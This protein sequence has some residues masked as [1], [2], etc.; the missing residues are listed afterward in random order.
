MS[1]HPSVPS[2]HDRITG[3]HPARHTALL[4]LRGYTDG[5]ARTVA[6]ALDALDDSALDD[7]YTYLCAVM[8]VTL[9]LTLTAQPAARDVGRAAEQAATA[10]PP[11]YEFAFGQAVRVGGGRHGGTDPRRRRGPPGGRASAGRDDRGPGRLRPRPRRPERPAQL[12]PGRPALI[13]TTA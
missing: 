8:D 5:D 10:A 11:H 9:R 1:H 2:P 7:T 3:P 12:P 13:A 6:S 4:L